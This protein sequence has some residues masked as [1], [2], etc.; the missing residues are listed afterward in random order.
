MGRRR[1]RGLLDMK[2]LC[3]ARV[4]PVTRE[5]LVKWDLA[6]WEGMGLMWWCPQCLS[7][8]SDKVHQARAFGPGERD[9]VLANMNNA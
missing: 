6:E 7:I 2:P 1:H 5:M 8:L 4:V 3:N 9:G